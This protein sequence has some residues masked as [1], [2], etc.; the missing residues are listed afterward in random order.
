VPVE[1]TQ[2]PLPPQT[3]T[4]AVATDA[5]AAT[6]AVDTAAASGDMVAVADLR[7]VLEEATGLTFADLPGAAAAQ[8]GTGFSNQATM[9]QDGQALFAYV[10]TDP[11]AAQ[12]FAAAVPQIP[13]A[14]GSATVANKNV[15]VV[16]AS[17]GETNHAKDVEAAVKAL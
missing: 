10:L 14:A 7:A 6:E 8:G 13:G 3:D 17:F 16:Y 15:I 2:E 5:P 4:T 11:Q 1:S 9:I 12:L